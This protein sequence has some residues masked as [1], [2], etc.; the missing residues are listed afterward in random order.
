MPPSTGA[1]FAELE[2]RLE[3]TT[4]ELED[5]LEETTTVELDELAELTATELDDNVVELATDDVAPPHTALV[6]VAPF[7]PT[8]AT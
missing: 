2:D 5:L 8:P 4:A 3:D 7:L 1:P 6:S